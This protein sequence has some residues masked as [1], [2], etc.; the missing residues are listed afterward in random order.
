LALCSISTPDCVPK[1][2]PGA[3]E[4]GAGEAGPATGQDKNHTAESPVGGAYWAWAGPWVAAAG[5]ELAPGQGENHATNSPPRSVCWPGPAPGQGEDHGTLQSGWI[6]SNFVEKHV[7]SK[8]PHLFKY[9]AHSI[10]EHAHDHHVTTPACKHR[11][12]ILTEARISIQVYYILCLPRLGGATIYFR[13]VRRCI[14]RHP[15]FSQLLFQLFQ[16]LLQLW[17]LII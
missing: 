1:G 3:L 12:A 10:I 2:F 4:R 11:L 16:G 13:T 5:P 17:F 15:L 14:L 7:V 9:I 6:V 8:C